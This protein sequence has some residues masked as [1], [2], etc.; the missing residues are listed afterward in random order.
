MRCPSW[1]SFE[2][3]RH[4]VNIR[5][6]IFPHVVESYC[7]EVYITTAIWKI[8]TSRR[9]RMQLLSGTR[10]IST[11]RASS[12]CS[13]WAPVFFPVYLLFPPGTV[14]FSPHI[15]AAVT[16]IQSAQLP[17]QINCLLPEAPTAGQKVLWL[18]LSLV[19]EQEVSKYSA[20]Y[21]GRRNSFLAK[22]IIHCSDQK[23][24]LAGIYMRFCYTLYGAWTYFQQSPLRLH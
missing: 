7:A 12:I 21:L 23:C 1:D 17:Q 11:P 8:R 18:S 20:F 9:K 3:L 14:A 2:N 16:A 5:C 19:T 4:L 6:V 24:E 15:T 10:N 22:N 13:N